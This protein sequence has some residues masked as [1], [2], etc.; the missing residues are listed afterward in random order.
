MHGIKLQFPMGVHQNN[1][2]EFYEALQND[3]LYIHRFW[4]SKSCWG[5]GLN[6]FFKSSLNESYVQLAWDIINAN[7]S[8][9]VLC[10]KITVELNFLKKNTD[11]LDSPQRF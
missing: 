10:F 3:R 9:S 11:V 5:S 4:I 2:G 7:Q 6:L 8:F 1:W